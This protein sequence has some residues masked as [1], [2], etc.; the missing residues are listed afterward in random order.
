M[1]CCLCPNKCGVDRSTKLGKC[2]CGTEAVVNRVALH[3]YEEP[4]VSGQY[5]SGTVF[6]G[7]CVMRCAFCQNAEISRAPRGKRYTPQMLADAYKY[8]EQ[9]GAHNINLV[10][11]TQW[12]DQIKRSLDIYR[13]SIPIVYNTSGYE[14]PEVIESLKDYVDVFLP[15]FKYS[16]GALAK[17]LS[18]R[19]DYPDVAETAIRKMLEIKPPVYED[20]LIK[21]G[22]IIRHLVLPGYVKNSFGVLDRIKSAFGTDVTLSLMSQFT[23]MPHC[24]DPGRPLKPIEYKAVVAHAVALG[25]EDVFVQECSSVGAEFIPPFDIGED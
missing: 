19:E 11:P 23:P 14:L 25:F 10:T 8:L 17:R 7:G 5:G 4:P 22:V 18:S 12:S 3:Y 6:F 20:D 15:D 13:P 2:L 9:E 21:S 16:D 1:E 24:A